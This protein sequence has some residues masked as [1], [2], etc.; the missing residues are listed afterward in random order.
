MSNV[1]GS[2]LDLIIRSRSSLVSRF[3]FALLDSVNIYIDEGTRSVKPS[4]PVLEPDLHLAG[5]QPWDLPGKSLS[6]CCIRMSLSSKFTH[7]KSSLAVCKPVRLV[8]VMYTWPS[9]EC[10]T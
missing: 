5:A 3:N 9:V 10:R 1:A 7:E 8:S 4:L 2:A 6:M